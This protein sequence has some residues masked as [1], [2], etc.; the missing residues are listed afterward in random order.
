MKVVR[1][2]ASRT[3]AFTPRNVPGTHFQLGLSR[4]QGHGMVGRKYITEKSS[5][6][7]GN[8]SQDRL[9]SSTIKKNKQN[10]NKFIVSLLKT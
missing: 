2:S 7:S 9:T 4:T 5:D 3:L 6:T 10:K 1:L 8:R